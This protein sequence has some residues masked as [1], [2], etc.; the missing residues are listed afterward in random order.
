MQRHIMTVA[1]ENLLALFALHKHST[2]ALFIDD[3]VPAKHK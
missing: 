1:A 2:A 3:D